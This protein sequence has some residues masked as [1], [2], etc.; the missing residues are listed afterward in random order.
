MNTLIITAH[1]S[2]NGFTHVIAKTYKKAK[3]VNGAKV[4]IIDLYNKKYSQDFLRF[5]EK[6]QLDKTDNK[7]AFHQKKIMWADEIV[8][9][10]PM[11]WGMEPAI[12]KNW[13][14]QNMTSGFAFKYSNKKPLGLLKNKNVKVFITSGGPNIFYSVSGLGFA[15]KYIWNI[16]KIK[17]CGMKLIEFKIFGNMDSKNRD[18][19]EILKYIKENAKS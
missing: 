2:K 19:D 13:F 9:V 14:D 4:K 17:Y 8:F 7:Q 15:L 16:V 5:E 1:P 6:K 12:L 3:E 11:W 18:T 10:F